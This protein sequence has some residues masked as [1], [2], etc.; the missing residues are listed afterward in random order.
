MLRRCIAYH[1]AAVHFVFVS[2]NR[3]DPESARVAAEFAGERVRVAELAEFASDPLDYA[4]AGR[5]AVSEWVDPDWILFLDSDEFWISAHA[6]FEQT[7]GLEG[8]DVYEVSRFN[9]A[10]IRNGNGTVR[11]LSAVD[12]ETLLI[13]ARHPM[14]AAFL[15]EHPETPWIN[16]RIGSKL[17]VRPAAV[18]ALSLGAHQFDALIPDPRVAVPRDIL[19]IH[20]PF[21]TEARFRGKVDAIRA[22]LQVHGHRFRGDMGWHWR[23]WLALDDAGRL[24]EE[25]VAQ[26]TDEERITMLLEHGTLTTPARL[27]AED[28]VASA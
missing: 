27:F 15:T 18:R 8:T 19:I 24:H 7:R 16:A 10:P 1:L 6:G 28:R 13:G 4:S 3:Q 17:M 21:T 25:F 11:C 5:L 20:L 23:R 26:L 9:A 12:R 22:M 2:L 14:D